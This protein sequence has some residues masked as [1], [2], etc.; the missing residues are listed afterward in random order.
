M[1]VPASGGNGIGKDATFCSW[2]SENDPSFGNYSMSV[3]S[4]ASPQIVIMEG[5][6]RR[7]RSGYWDGRVFT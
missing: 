1:K 7:W 4:E 3:D 5:K 6:K 2:K